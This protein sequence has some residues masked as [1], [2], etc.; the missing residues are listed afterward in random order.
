MSGDEK[1]IIWWPPAW[2]VLNTL[3][4]LAILVGTA[5]WVLDVR[6]P[7]P[8]LPTAQLEALP[9]D[10]QA[11]LQWKSNESVKTDVEWQYDQRYAWRENEYNPP[12]RWQSV[13]NRESHVV[14]DLA[15]GWGYVFRVRAVRGKKRGRPSNEVAVTPTA[16]PTRLKSLVRTTLP[17]VLTLFHFPNARLAPDGVPAGEGVMVP[18]RAVIQAMA[19][20]DGCARPGAPVTVRPYG[21]ASDAP[22]LYA[23]WRPMEDS[24]A[25]NLA[26]AELRARD[27]CDALKERATAH[28]HVR[29]EEP[30]EWSSLEQMVQ[31]RDDGSLITY[32]DDVQ[33]R[34]PWR[35]VVVL[36]VRDPGRCTFE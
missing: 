18:E 26:T 17:Q 34:E 21:F 33:D 20:L 9:G 8:D 10:R 22:F 5:W 6:F 3:A 28:P 27:A 15:N 30:Y 23:D 35:R 36:K 12:S 13:P 2:A 19:A 14:T 25:L 31:T 11:I 16:V 1:K 4:A 24:D 7:D 32:P 29:I